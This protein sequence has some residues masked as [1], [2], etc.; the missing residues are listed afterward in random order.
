MNYIAENVVQSVSA[1]SGISVSGGSGSTPSISNTGVL[2]LTAGTNITITGTK[3]NYTIN[4]SGG[5]SSGV[6]SLN[7][8]TGALSLLAGNGL[9]IDNT[10]SDE[11]TVSIN[12]TGTIT[13]EVVDVVGTGSNF[14]TFGVY[15]RVGGSYVPP[16]QPLELAPVQYVDDKPIGVATFNT[17]IGDVV[18]AP[19][20]N[21]TLDAVG[22]T[23]TVNASGGS[24]GAMWYYIQ[25]LRSRGAMCYCIKQHCMRHVYVAL[26]DLCRHQVDAG[27]SQRRGPALW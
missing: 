13:T 5:G 14:S 25:Q 9:S 19:G 24:G 21:I 22:N 1:G 8:K 3:S 15:P 4:A 10:V 26:M 6:S 7:S 2:E 27:R 16:T 20:T 11:I 18:L 17:L 12:T 23:I